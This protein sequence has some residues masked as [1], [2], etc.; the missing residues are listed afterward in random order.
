MRKVDGYING[1]GSFLT[2]VSSSVTAFSSER[3]EFLATPNPN[4]KFKCSLVSF[5]IIQTKAVI[6]LSQKLCWLI[7]SLDYSGKDILKIYVETHF[8]TILYFGILLTHS[9]NQC[10]PSP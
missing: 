10:L 6:E 8:L 2:C 5:Y 9:L 3:I 7:L 4:T 1:S